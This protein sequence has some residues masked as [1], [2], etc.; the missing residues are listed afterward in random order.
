[1][2]TNFIQILGDT[3]T[4]KILDFLIENDREHW[5][6]VEIR[7]NAKVGYSTLKL[8]IPKM[9]KKKLIIVD[10]KVGKSN[11]LKINKKNLVVQKIYDLYNTIN[12]QEIKMFINK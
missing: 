10:K 8:I 9:I 6:M 7:D 4:N 11:L 3:P 2:N 5:T 12:K 1:M